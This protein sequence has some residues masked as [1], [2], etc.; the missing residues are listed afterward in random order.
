MTTPDYIQKDSDAKDDFETLKLKI[1]EFSKERD[2]L[3]FH[4]PKNLAMA[5]S[6]EAGELMEHFQ[7]VE[8]GDS[9]SL[10]QPTRLKIQEEMADVLIYLLRLAD[11]LDVDLKTAAINK[12]DQN[13][14]KY[15]ADKVRGSSKKYTDYDA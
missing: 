14:E 8:T 1:R 2:W 3:Q 10:P 6:V 11:E 7:W 13:A 12:I 15:P 9:R 4:S 5:L